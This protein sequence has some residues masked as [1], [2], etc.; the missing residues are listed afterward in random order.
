MIYFDYYDHYSIE[1]CLLKL[2]IWII[3]VIIVI[4]IASCF[5][6]CKLKRCFK[7]LM[8][9]F[10]IALFI[11]T[12]I[13][14]LTTFIYEFNKVKFERSFEVAS[15]VFGVTICIILCFSL[16]LSFFIV[17]RHNWLKELDKIRLRFG[18]FFLYFRRSLWASLYWP[19]FLLRYLIIVTILISVNNKI[20]HVVFLNFF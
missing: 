15:F 19:F 16:I 4:P 12:F 10:T 8:F 14:F 7:N 18:I 5:Y 6:C 2:L 1:N 11:I 13:P 3:Y 20:V 9:S 17:F